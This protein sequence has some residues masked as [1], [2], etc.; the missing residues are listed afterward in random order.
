MQSWRITS[1]YECNIFAQTEVIPP[2]L[3]RTANT[4][5][6]TAKI[7]DLAQT[8]LKVEAVKIVSFHQV[9]QGLGLKGGQPRIT[10]LPVTPNKAS[11][12]EKRAFKI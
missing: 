3:S 1:P 8:I 10:N 4:P 6:L 12:M 11:A 9:A 2:L 5:F 7:V